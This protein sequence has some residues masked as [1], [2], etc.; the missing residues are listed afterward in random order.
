MWL[1]RIQRCSHSRWGCAKGRTK[2]PK[3]VRIKNMCHTSCDWNFL[4]LTEGKLAGFAFRFIHVE[5][6]FW[7]TRTCSGV[8]VT[9]T[10]VNVSNW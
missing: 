1:L 3:S 7:I 8:E 2:Y 9:G 5:V 6:F 4:N 10:S